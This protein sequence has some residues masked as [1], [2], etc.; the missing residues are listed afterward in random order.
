MFPYQ[1]VDLDFCFAIHYW[2]FLVRLAWANPVVEGWH[3]IGPGCA[4]FAAQFV[5]SAVLWVVAGIAFAVAFVPSIVNA[6]VPFDLAPFE[7]TSILPWAIGFATGAPVGVI[8]PVAW[9]LGI[10]G[11]GAIAGRRMAALEL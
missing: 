11:L 4:S 8:T 2:F 7:P 10:V 5:D 9:A 6:L 1:P 3:L